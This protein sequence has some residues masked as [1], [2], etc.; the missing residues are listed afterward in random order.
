MQIKQPHCKISFRKSP[1]LFQ[2][3]VRFGD[4]AYVVSPKKLRGDILH[5]RQAYKKG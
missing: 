5:S 1:K 4:D 2:Y 3:F